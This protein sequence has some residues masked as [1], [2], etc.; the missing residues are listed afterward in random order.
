MVPGFN[1][2]EWDRDK[3]LDWVI[4]DE[5]LTDQQLEFLIYFGQLKNRVQE[6]EAEVKETN[7]SL[8][9][10]QNRFNAINR[11]NANLHARINKAITTINILLTPKRQDNSF[12]SN[13]AY[14]YEINIIKRILKGDNN[15]QIHKTFEDNNET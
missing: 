3:I 7:T 10:W 4:G 12:H 13:P 2:N 14:I 5:P 6:L 8:T 1:P 11:Q 15:E 9:W